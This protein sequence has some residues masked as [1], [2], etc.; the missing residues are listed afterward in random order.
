[1]FYSEKI[2]DSLKRF[3]LCG[4]TLVKDYGG[5]VFTVCLKT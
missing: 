3:L 4:K 1:M 5:F 2:I